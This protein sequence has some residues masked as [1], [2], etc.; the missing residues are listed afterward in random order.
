MINFNDYIIEKVNQNELLNSYTTELNKK[1]SKYNVK[2]L[3]LCYVVENGNKSLEVDIVSKNEYL[4]I[5][6]NIRNT[7]KKNPLKI[8]V[9]ANFGSIDGE[10]TAQIDD[11]ISEL[12][13]IKNV[14]DIL[15]SI[16]YSRIPVFTE[17]EYVDLINR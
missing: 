17:E 1:L 14:I 4:D 10:N 16:N 9:R 7:N 12:E 5:R 3:S 2:I 6:K 13:T 8:V 15:M 11:C